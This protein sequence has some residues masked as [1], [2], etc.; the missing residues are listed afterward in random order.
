M[1]VVVEREHQ[2]RRADD[3]AEVLLAV[4]PDSRRRG[5]GSALLAAVEQQVKGAGRTTVL[6]QVDEPP[7]GED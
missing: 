4:H 2:A 3:P 5:V 1:E 7:G 6:G